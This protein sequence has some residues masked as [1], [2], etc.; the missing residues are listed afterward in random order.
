MMVN[1]IIKL[2]ISYSGNTMKSGFSIE[3]QVLDQ[4]YTTGCQG[5]GDRRKGEGWTGYLGFVDV[6][7]KYY[8]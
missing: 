1:T 6:N 8:I 5:G 2:W 7:P 3:N 4:Y